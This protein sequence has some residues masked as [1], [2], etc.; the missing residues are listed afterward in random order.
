MKAAII[1]TS[2]ANGFH[3]PTSPPNAGAAAVSATAVEI[4]NV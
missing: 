3:R 4:W 1:A 2:A